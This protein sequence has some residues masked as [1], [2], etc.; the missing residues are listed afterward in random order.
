MHI[1]VLTGVQNGCISCWSYLAEKS[2]VLSLIDKSKGRLSA[3]GF[4]D[5][6]TNLGKKFGF[7]V[8]NNLCG[9]C[10]NNAN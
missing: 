4:V 5:V 6:F 2:L 8:C 9:H 7:S 3:N 1:S 10:C